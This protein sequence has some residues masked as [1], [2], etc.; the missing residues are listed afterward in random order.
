MARDPVHTVAGEHDRLSE[1]PD[2]V[3]LN[4]LGRL[5]DAGD[6]RTVARTS[7]LSRRWRPLPWPQLTNIYLDVGSFITQSDEW[8]PARR[9]R[10]RRFGEHHHATAG[11]T[12]ALARFLAAARAERAGDREAEAQVH[13]DQARPR[14]PHRRPRR[15]RGQH[16]RGQG[17]GARD[18]HRA[19]VRLLR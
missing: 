5:A 1:L 8:I 3:L 18:R 10:Q 9:R 13:P 16:R 6:V 11:F 14:A 17:R 15:R 19:R 7:I 4:I 12:D 2:D